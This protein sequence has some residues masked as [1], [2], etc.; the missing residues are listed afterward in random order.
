[1]VLLAV[2]AVSLI[3]QVPADAD[4]EQLNTPAAAAAQ[5]TRDGLAAVPTAPQVVVVRSVVPLRAV[6]EPAAAV[7]P[8]IAP[9]VVRAVA[10]S[11]VAMPRNAGSVAV[12][13]SACVVVV[14]AAI[15]FGAVAA[16]SPTIT[17]CAAKSAVEASVEVEE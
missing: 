15:V 9:G 16:P 11:A 1:M 17:P 13:K 8:P 4:A 10:I 2:T 3:T 6:N 14:D 7:V 12:A 5:A